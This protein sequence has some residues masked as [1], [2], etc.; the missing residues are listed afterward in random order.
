[1]C[2][3]WSIES[4]PKWPSEGPGCAARKVALG[5]RPIGFFGTV[6]FGGW[7]SSRCCRAQ[8]GTRRAKADIAI[9]DERHRQ[10][11]IDGNDHRNA[12]SLPHVFMPCECCAKPVYRP[13]P[14]SR[15]Q[16]GR[17]M[18][19]SGVNDSR[20][21]QAAC[22]ACAPGCRRRLTVVAIQPLHNAID[23]TGADDGPRCGLYLQHSTPNLQTG[24]GARDSG[25]LGPP[26]I[27]LRRLA[28]H[29]RDKR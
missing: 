3:A 11:K 26:L 22:T 27:R 10:E 17:T 25:Q 23:N 7:P 15:S 28:S 24:R 18:T 12:L 20:F 5:V 16:H 19:W 21:P 14:S 6:L 1:M 13:N 29:A 9:F 4:G 2:T 8:A